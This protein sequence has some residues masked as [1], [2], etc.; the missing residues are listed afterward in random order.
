MRFC[1]KGSTDNMYELESRRKGTREWYSE[2]RRSSSIAALKNYA[3]LQDT[4]YRIV[5]EKGKRRWSFMAR[6]RRK[7]PGSQS[8]LLKNFTGVVRLN[9]DKTVSIVGAE[10]KANPAKKVYEYAVYVV[11]G[12]GRERRGPTYLGTVSGTSKSDALSRAGRS[13][14]GDKRFLRIGERVD[15]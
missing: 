14:W 7:N 15:K 8:K 2:G 4:D 3:T 1:R 5:D 6:S 10:K 11:S 12:T 13:G 9:K